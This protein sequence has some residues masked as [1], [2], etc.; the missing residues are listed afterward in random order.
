M[1]PREIV[2]EQIHHRETAE[3]PYTLAFEADV[4]SRLDEHFGG[5]AWRGR[6]VRYITRCGSV[7]RVKSERLDDTHNRDAFG[8][9]WRTDELPR[10]VV[11]PGLKSPSF[12]GYAFPSAETFMDP[13]VT[14][15]VKQRVAE[16]AS[17]FTIV[18]TGLCLWQSWYLRGFQNRKPSESARRR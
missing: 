14:A 17:S 3:I 2:L 1:T 8:T 18:S 11:E 13:T 10:T 16:S 9:V 7:A 5:D 12:Q 4:G 15:N 6:L